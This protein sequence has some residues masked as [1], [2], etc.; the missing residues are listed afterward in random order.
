MI[1]AI[2]AQAISAS[3]SPW[4]LWL[5]PRAIHMGFLVDKLALGMVSLQVLGLSPLTTIPPM[6]HTH[7]SF[8]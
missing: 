3:P 8:S 5:S 6:F 2:L 4:R 7:I 1:Y